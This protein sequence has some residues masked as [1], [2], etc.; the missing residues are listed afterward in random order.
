MLHLYL[1]NCGIENLEA[2][3]VLKSIKRKRRAK[4]SDAG[5]PSRILMR[6]HGAERRLSSVLRVPSVEAEDQRNLNRHLELLNKD[7]TT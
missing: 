1:L 2:L 6:Y 5:K 3:P 4:I 7:G